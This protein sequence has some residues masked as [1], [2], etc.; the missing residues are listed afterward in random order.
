M[1]DI[2]NDSLKINAGKLVID[3]AN[4]TS[5]LIK[6]NYNSAITR[7]FN[8]FYDVKRDE[9]TITT[10]TANGNLKIKDGYIQ[11][12]INNS[13]IQQAVETS[14]WFTQKLLDSSYYSWSKA[15]ISDHCTT[16]VCLHDL[17]NKNLDY[18][19]VTKKITSVANQRNSLFTYLTDAL[20]A[21]RPVFSTDSIYFTNT[22]YLTTLEFLKRKPDICIFIV[23]K[24][25]NFGT[26]GKVRIFKT[27]PPSDTHI[28]SYIYLEVESNKIRVSKM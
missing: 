20:V 18:D 19:F 10:D 17:S 28:N 25:E 11:S 26:A 1:L 22:Q 14:S 21:N 24:I 13:Y 6:L 12:I 8:R 9:V 23:F 16:Q 7:D 27:L 5:H 4:L 15:W 3:M 2:D